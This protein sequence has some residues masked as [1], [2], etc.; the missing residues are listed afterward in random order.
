MYA[1][2]LVARDDGTRFVT[3]K[4]KEWKISVATKD[5][6]LETNTYVYTHL[7]HPSL[8]DCEETHKYVRVF[9]PFTV[10]RNTLQRLTG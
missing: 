6:R 5:S 1:E 2:R 3:P 7:A 8:K 9:L 4:L 10:D